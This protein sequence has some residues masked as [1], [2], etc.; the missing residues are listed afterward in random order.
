MSKRD[1]CYTHIIPAYKVTLWHCKTVYLIFAKTA[2]NVE[3]R[4]LQ[5]CQVNHH[6]DFRFFKSASRVP[7]AMD[8]IIANNEK[9]STFHSIG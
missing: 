8:K 3:K 4:I 7:K 6:T 1:F 2:E 9:E 5:I